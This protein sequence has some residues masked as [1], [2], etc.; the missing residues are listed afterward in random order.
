MPQQQTTTRQACV[1]DDDGQQRY[2]TIVDPFFQLLLMAPLSI[3]KEHRFPNYLSEMKFM[4]L[5]VKERRNAGDSGM[6]S[7]QLFNPMSY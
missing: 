1:N 6:D 7:C 4:R 5:E 3:T 2:R